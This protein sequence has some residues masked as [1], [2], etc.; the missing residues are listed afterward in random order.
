METQLVPVIASKLNGVPCSKAVISN[1]H[2]R[3]GTVEGSP[4]AVC[5]HVGPVCPTITLTQ[6]RHHA[7]LTNLLSEQLHIKARMPHNNNLF[8]P[9]LFLAGA[10]RRV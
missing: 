7:V 10:N 8:S 6:P 4:D 5:D 3:T 2:H 9:D 1:T